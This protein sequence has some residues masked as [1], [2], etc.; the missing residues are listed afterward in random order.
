MCKKVEIIKCLQDNYTYL[1]IN[2]K[3]IYACIVDPG[4][5]EPVIDF[6]QKKQ[7]CFSIEIIAGIPPSD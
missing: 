7:P 3:N 4:E 5:A 1:I 6:I 2:E